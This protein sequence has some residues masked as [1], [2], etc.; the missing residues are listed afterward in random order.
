MS[1]LESR[2]SYNFPIIPGISLNKE[3][4]YGPL[5]NAIEEWVHEGLHDWSN[6]GAGHGDDIRNVVSTVKPPT[7]ASGLSDFQEMIFY[8][9]GL[10][11]NP[12]K[13]PLLSEIIKNVL[14]KENGGGR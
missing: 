14:N 4:L 6:F 13:P 7:K 9:N 8:L 3:A 12:L 10:R 2:S 11:H 5:P 1:I